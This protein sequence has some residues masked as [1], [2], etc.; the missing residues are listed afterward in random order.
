[1]SRKVINIYPD[2]LDEFRLGIRKKTYQLVDVRQPHEFAAGHIPG[3]CLIPLPDIEE[4]LGEVC[5]KSN[6]I[7]YCRSGGRSAVAATLI[8]DA[9]PRQGCIHNLVGGISGWEGKV[10]KDIPHLRLFPR[11]LSLGQTLFRAINLEKGSIL[12]YSYLA[13]EYSGTELGKM[14]SQLIDQEE[15]HARC[16]FAYWQ[17]HAAT[18]SA[19]NFSTLFSRLDGRIMEDG[20]SI[21]AWLAPLGQ[22]PQDRIL[23]IL[24]L[25]CEIEYHSYDLYRGLAKQSSDPAMTTSCLDLAEQEKD[26]ARLISRSLKNHS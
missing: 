14:A 6:V 15:N 3:A 2:E 7:L 16:I 20:R 23:R 22:T 1:M 11:D 21:A 26:H 4:R 12:F 17:Q 9:A 8:K 5:P 18:P 13:E 25:A 24:E 10:L 19:D